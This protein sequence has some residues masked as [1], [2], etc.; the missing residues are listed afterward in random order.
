MKSK[1]IHA[2]LYLVFLAGNYLFAQ[3]SSFTVE[4][5]DIQKGLT[6]N[7]V[8]TVY[9]DMYGFI[10]IGTQDGL[11]KFDGYSFTQYRKDP[12]NIFSLS[13]NFVVKIT[14]NKN[15][16]LWIATNDGL[17]K[18]DF[19]T[20][21]FISVL[22]NKHQK[23]AKFSIKI[24][25]IIED[26]TGV[27]WLRTNEGIMEYHPEKN[28]FF[29]YLLPFEA[30]QNISNDNYFTFFSDKDFNLW[31][32]S[33]NGIVRFNKKTKQFT[34]YDIAQAPNAEVL[35]V[36]R[37]TD[38]IFIVGTKYG[39][40]YFY[41]KSEKTRKINTK[42]N[43]T[44]VK[45]ILKDDSN[46]IWVGTQY[47]L[48]Y[49]DTVNNELVSFSLEK[50]VKDEIKIGNIDALM[51]DNSGI[52][53]VGTNYG[54]FKID[55]RIKSFHLYRKEKGNI[56]NFSSNSIFSVY[57]DKKTNE[58]WFGTRGY[59]LNVFNR[60]T[61]TVTLYN[62][63]NTILRDNFIHCIR[64]ESSENLWLGT[65][66][67]I[68]IVNPY[69]R[70]FSEFIKNKN[71]ELQ[72]FF[73][74]NRITDIYF[75]NDIVWVASFHGLLKY[76]SSGYK[77][78]KNSGD[79]NS[80]V[81]DRIFKLVKTNDTTIWIATHNGLSKFNPKNEVFTNYT[82]ENGKISSN[83]VPYVFESSD[84]TVWVGTGTGL[85]K[86]ISEK[87]SFIFYTI[88]S[89]NFSNDFIY[90][91]TEDS[92]HILWLST[93]KGIIRF[94]PTNEEVQNFSLTDN[95]QDYE[96]NVG[97][98]YNSG[99]EI[100]WGGTKGLNSLKPERFLKQ[101][102]S[103]LP[104]ITSF[105]IKNSNHQKSINTY[106]LKKIHLSGNENSFEINFAIPEYSNPVNNTFKYRI[107]EKDTTWTYIGTNHSITFFE[108]APGTYT[109][110]LNGSSAGNTWN[111]EHLELKIIISSPWWQSPIA[112]LSYLLIFGFIVMLIVF[113]YN[114]GLRKENKILHE[115]QVV[116]KQ[117]EEQ[118]ELLS[119][120]N[121]NI[122]ESLRYASGIINAL[123]PSKISIDNLLSDY[124]I[125]YM[126]KEIVSG[127][128]YWI[129]AKNG[130]IIVAAG[131]STGHGV[132]GA[133]MSIIGMELLRNTLLKGIEKPSEI[134]DELNKN[135][136]QIFKK[137][138]NSKDLK[139]GMD[140]SIISI[141]YLESTIEF[142]GAINQ[143]Y[144]IRDDNIIEVKGNRFSVSP[145]SWLQYGKFTNH[146]INIEDNDMIYMFSDGY[147]D[148]F[149]GPDESKFKYRRFRNLLLNNYTKAL[150]EQEKILKRVI[151]S[152]KGNIEQVDDIMVIGIRIH[153]KKT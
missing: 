134:L 69:T 136:A 135:L 114:R 124:F 82:V 120:K 152:W 76:K 139:D 111:P 36:Y 75:D 119:I 99:E 83:M 142:S 143:L 144:I 29:K 148:Q 52:V 55:S 137:E 71:P 90:T 130:K 153:T 149:G 50:Y 79:I 67:G 151:N 128:F 23:N 138:V 54:I 58:I 115:K 8:N 80:I 56:P 19:K 88:Q 66:N 27:L 97:A 3:N 9:Q 10:W 68:F 74:N 91:I 22:K 84:K 106:N 89:H 72:S 14:G 127:D 118:K 65:E 49:L 132:P 107:K 93:N 122:A 40:H 24:K 108:L 34:V 31:T 1:F 113:L 51:K 101:N 112:Y 35:S 13:D 53:W 109:F 39:I 78:Y 17:N 129:E 141:N 95:L 46:I 100:F 28:K 12:N 4:H 121:N 32:G 81:G 59:G 85:N 86:Y 105:N 98:V 2:F 63:E 42:L 11:N 62:Q 61:Q 33:G 70:V 20:N 37:L 21:T 41:P 145:A 5:F 16:G 47:G 102:F 147:T 73:T 26:E 30:S 45:S 60:N 104:I 131:D 87:D 125:L 7:T 146:V 150:D 57:Y 94:N 133:F 18:Y 48:M 116:A 44:G 15:T 103:P 92:N 126:S 77:I 25:N 123:L 110:Q 117:V 64:K 96:F 140:I 6:Q 43:F 38:E